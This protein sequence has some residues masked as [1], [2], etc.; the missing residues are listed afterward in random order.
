M[1]TSPQC[2]LLVVH[3]CSQDWAA[4][5]AAMAAAGQLQLQLAALHHTRSRQLAAAGE[6][7]AASTSQEAAQRC[8]EEAMEQLR[9]GGQDAAAVEAQLQQAELLLCALQEG[10]DAAADLRPALAG[11]L[12][13]LQVG[14]VHGRVGGRLWAGAMV[15]PE[16][17]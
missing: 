5:P 1:S 7:A 12:A 11:V 17:C 2:A 16:C 3:P 6:A 14:W 13:L 10:E 15:S 9:Q 4:A 8:V